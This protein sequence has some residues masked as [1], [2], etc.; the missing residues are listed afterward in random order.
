M[1]A[2]RSTICPS[3][4]A[5][6]QMVHRFAGSGEGRH[7][8]VHRFE[9]TR[10]RRPRVVS[11]ARWRHTRGALVPRWRT[12]SF[13]LHSLMRGRPGN[14]GNCYQSADWHQHPLSSL[15][16]LMAQ[17]TPNGGSGRTRALA[18]TAAMSGITRGNEY[19]SIVFGTIWTAGT[20]APHYWLSKLFAEYSRSSVVSPRSG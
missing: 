7:T 18:D 8:K 2:P 1:S 4:S 10:S 11:G 3:L 15:V 17:M 5:R 9:R 14:S 20:F 12:R 6:I 19:A 13:F 16:D